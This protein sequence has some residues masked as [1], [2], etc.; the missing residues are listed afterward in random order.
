MSSS[1]ASIPA[2]IPSPAVM[3]PPVEARIA[4]DPDSEPESDPEPGIGVAPKLRSKAPK[5]P[6]EPARGDSEKRAVIYLRVSTTEQAETTTEG[7]GYSIPAQRE[8]AFRKARELGADVVDE[9]V[10][11]GESAKTADR[12]ALQLLMHR[13]QSLTDIDYVIV[14][15]VDRLARNRADDANL[16]VSIYKHGAKLVSCT[17]QIDD[18]PSGKLVHGIMATI[19][20]WYSANLATEATK[21]MLQKAK[22]GGTPGRAPIGY[23]NVIDQTNG[24]EVRTV[25]IDPVAS[26]HVVW[27]FRT[28][29][30]G[31]YSLI[32]LTEM[33]ADRGL[34][35]LP[36][37]RRPAVRLHMSL[38]SAMMRNRYYLGIVTFK[39]VEYQG[40]HPPL[41]DEQ[42][43]QAVQ[44]LLDERAKARVK[45]RTHRHYLTGSIYCARC[46][47]RLCFTRCTG[48]AGVKYDYFFCPGKR[49]GVCTQPF[50]AVALIEE[51]IE[52]VY[53]RVRLPDEL[54]E[55]IRTQVKEQVDKDQADLQRQLKKHR[56]KK[57]AHEDAHKRLLDLYLEGLLSMEEFKSE[58]AKVKRQL[59]ATNSALATTQVRYQDIEQSLEHTLTIASQC[60]RIYREASEEIRRLFNN[61]LF[62]RI[63]VVNRP[64]FLGG[65]RPWK[66]GW[67]YATR[68]E[69]RAS[70]SE[71]LHR[72]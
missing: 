15:K 47:K 14:H 13:L 29:A 5:E 55:V 36:T 61:G 32:D 6:K 70:D 1:A 40:N 59:S 8:A 58:Q 43:F 27:A 30:S 9:Y 38:V 54:V 42:T 35:S 16:T 45:T 25:I 22:Q 17:E 57:K 33:L 72:H 2:T 4:I 39:G 56:G 21:G 10:D 44:D 20:E 11:R 65:S 37:K 48:R 66:R 26:D 53:A 28:F 52:E 60:D 50:L 67:S 7:D 46:K 49:E 41:I 19:N 51:A 69:V 24:R 34:V 64:G 18:T 3:E 63:Y 12:P 62:A 68:I 23:R 31:E 71:A